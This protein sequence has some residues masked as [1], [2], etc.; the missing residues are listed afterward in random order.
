MAR[1]TKGNNTKQM[2]F[3]IREMVIALCWLKT[4]IADIVRR[5]I[6]L[7]RNN[8]PAQ[9]SS[10]IGSFWMCLIVFLNSCIRSLS[11]FFAMSISFASFFAIPKPIVIPCSFCYTRLTNAIVFVFHVLIGR[12]IR[13]RFSLLAFDAGFCYNRI[14]HLCFSVKRNC[15]ELFRGDEPLH[16]LFYCSP[17]IV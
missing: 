5:M 12:I 7:S 1:C 14:R 9:K 17:K 8:C 11:S 3:S 4:S 10:S 6:Y 15:L 13:K 2:L 16:S